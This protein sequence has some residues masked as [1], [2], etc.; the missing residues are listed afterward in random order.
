MPSAPS[1]EA[2]PAAKRYG[3]IA[4]ARHGEPALSRRI[5]LSAEGYRRWWAAYEE[6]GILD[7]QTPPA[8]LLQIV[9]EADVIFASSRRR[10]IETAEAVV[11]GRH[12]VRDSMFYEAPLPPP[13]APGWLKLGPRHWGVIARFVWWLGHTEGQETRPEAQ[14]RAALVAERLAAEAAKGQNVVLLA[15]GF[16]NF[17]VGSSLKKS[18]WTL[19]SGKGHKYWSTRRYER[20]DR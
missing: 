6:G 19:K 4:I 16:F 1:P 9:R 15:H 3:S 12:F 8:E 13:R 14:V 17:M 11:Q 20:K 10:A 7:A 5:K 2:E 18:G